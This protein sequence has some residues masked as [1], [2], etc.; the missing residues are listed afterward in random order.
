MDG[1]RLHAGNNQ[2]ITVRSFLPNPCVVGRGSCSVTHAYIWRSHEEGDPLPYTLAPLSISFLGIH[3]NRRRRSA[4]ALH[5][6]CLGITSFCQME[7]GV[8]Y[9]NRRRDAFQSHKSPSRGNFARLASVECKA[10]RDREGYKSPQGS[11]SI[12][13]ELVKIKDGLSSEN[14]L[15]NIRPYLLGPM[16]FL[17]ATFLVIGSPR[18]CLPNGC[19]RS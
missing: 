1:C 5:R 15:F 6:R 10:S 14:L 12:V 9:G 18:W 4:S 17:T 8:V 2:S 3:S 19:Q 11:H 13:E 7:K 16:V